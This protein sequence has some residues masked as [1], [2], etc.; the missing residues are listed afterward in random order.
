M[1]F[2]ELENADYHVVKLHR[3]M[4]VDGGTRLSV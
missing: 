4:T 2:L 1:R 3:F